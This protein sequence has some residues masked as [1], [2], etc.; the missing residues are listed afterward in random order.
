MDALKQELF[1]KTHI[2]TQEQLIGLSVVVGWKIGIQF[3]TLVRAFRNDLDRDRIF[4]RFQVTVA[5]VAGYCVCTDEEGK[6]AIRPIR[7]RVDHILCRVRCAYTESHSQRRI[8][9]CQTCKTGLKRI[10]IR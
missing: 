1:V 7:V 2:K 10:T 9:V 3:W 5:E 8:A 6:L 4:S